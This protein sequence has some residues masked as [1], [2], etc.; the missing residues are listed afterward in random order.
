MRVITGKYK[1]RKL[2][3]LADNEIRP[4]MDRVKKY[5]FDV[6]QDELHQ[7]V[8]LDLFA[9]T[10]AFGIE[11]LSQGARQ[12][13]FVDSGHRAVKS[14]NENLKNIKVE[15]NTIVLQQKAERFVAQA[16]FKYDLIFCDAPYDY[17][18][19]EKLI[20]EIFEKDLLEDDGCLILEHYAKM[21]F[22]ERYN[23]YYRERD[24]KFGKTIITMFRKDH[25]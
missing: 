19:L 15:E 16:K 12:A 23:H 3:N 6:L 22:Q 20:K 21:Q 18:G 9:G 14:I 2:K 8:V 24:K 11:A 4:V 17:V 13:I 5:V 25:G 10:G 7:K 1:G